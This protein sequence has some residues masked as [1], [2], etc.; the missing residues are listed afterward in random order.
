M[1][2]TAV[3]K[4]AYNATWGKYVFAGMYDKFLQRVETYGLSYK[5]NNRPQ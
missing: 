2:T 3:L 4:K 5:S 1:S